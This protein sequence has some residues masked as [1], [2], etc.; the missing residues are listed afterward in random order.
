M[1]HAVQIK[2]LTAKSCRPPGSSPHS[3]PGSANADTDDSSADDDHTAAGAVTAR[4]NRKVSGWDSRGDDAF[5]AFLAE[6][7]LAKR[8][9]GENP[10]R[11]DGNP[12]PAALL[13]EG[14]YV[15]EMREVASAGRS[16]DV[17]KGSHSLLGCIG[18]SDSESVADSRHGSD[19]D[20][21]AETRSSDASRRRHNLM[22]PR[23]TS[24]SEDSLLAMEVGAQV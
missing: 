4:D 23:S 6:T 15:D 22:E 14:R 5:L 12:V 13:P 2:K 9:A 10:E 3:T 11:S 20:K 24:G 8:R 19:G 21:A 18:T 16:G 17:T 1:S 7:D